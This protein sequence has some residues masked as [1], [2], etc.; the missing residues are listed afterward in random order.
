[1]PRLKI[2]SIKSYVS[3]LCDAFDFPDEVIIDCLQHMADGRII[4]FSE[5]HDYVTWIGPAPM[6]GIWNNAHLSSLN[7]TV[8]NALLQEINNRENGFE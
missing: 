6:L 4:E 3:K 1:M 2:T 7:A 5:D 8:W